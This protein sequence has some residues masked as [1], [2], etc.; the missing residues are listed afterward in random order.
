MFFMAASTAT[1]AISIHLTTGYWKK[2]RLI[3]RNADVAPPCWLKRR[4]SLLNG[5]VEI[6]P[7]L[8]P[9]REAQAEP[10]ENAKSG[11]HTVQSE[12]TNEEKGLEMFGAKGG[13]RTP[14][15]L[16]ARS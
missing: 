16:P 5:P 3:C 15:V 6:R 8:G 7:W 13:T 4:V 12:R 2:S 9:Y 14:T 11:G 10:G 1:T